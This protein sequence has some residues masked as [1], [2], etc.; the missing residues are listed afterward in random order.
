MPTIADLP[1]EV[2]LATI[3]IGP[4][5]KR[6]IIAAT[7]ILW[8]ELA[9]STNEPAILISYA[10]QRT[11]LYVTVLCQES[12]SE[13]GVRPPPK[14]EFPSLQVVRLGWQARLANVISRFVGE[15]DLKA[16]LEQL[17]IQDRKTGALVSIDE[18]GKWPGTL[19]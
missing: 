7:E 1:R 9:D 4:W 19:G 18:V 10:V 5:H 13:N 15:L 14:T 16:H 11:K 12:E 6:I 3:H 17:R 8:D 2:A